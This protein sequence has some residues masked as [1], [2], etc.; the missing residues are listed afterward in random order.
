MLDF[1]LINRKRSALDG[2]YISP[3]DSAGWQENVLGEGKLPN[4]QMVTIRISP[5]EQSA[6]WDLRVEIKSRGGAEWKNLTLRE[7]SKII[8]RISEDEKTFLPKSNSDARAY[9]L[10]RLPLHEILLQ[11][12]TQ[13]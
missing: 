5:E 3:H 10:Q 8:L 2:I 7:I 6:V 4:G 1:T 13:S 12:I 11:L 9:H